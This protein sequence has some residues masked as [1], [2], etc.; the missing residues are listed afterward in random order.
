[1]NNPWNREPTMLLAA[2]QAVLALVVSFGLNLTAEQVGAIMAASAAIIG[3]I[4]RS[5]VT[6]TKS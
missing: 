1:M 5:Q 2:I 3:L 4:T 6:P